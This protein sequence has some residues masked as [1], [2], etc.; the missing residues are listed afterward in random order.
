DHP[1]PDRRHVRHR[2]RPRPGSHR[3]RRP[4][5]AAGAR[6]RRR[7]G[8]E[9]RLPPGPGAARRPGRSRHPQRRRPSGRRRRG[10]A[11]PCRG[12]RR[13]RP[14]LS[15]APAR[16]GG[17]DRCQPHVAGGADPRAAAPPAT[18]PG[19]RRVRELLSR[20]DGERR[21]VGVR[22][23]QV[24]APGVRRRAACR[25]D[26]ERRAR[27]DGLSEPDGHAHAGEGARAGGA[28]LRRVAVD[29]PRDGRHD[30]PARAR[31]A[32]RRDDPRRH[33]PSG[34]AA[35]RHL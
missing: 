2:C 31:P 32:A 12:G 23:V 15:A 4:R 7:V 21:L 29:Q 20:A 30:D 34:D 19:N 16:L 27:D 11:G 25:G 8:V 6:R 35:T 9:R 33:R 14:R 5:G 17:A 3:P 1:R 26:R 13:A 10:V 18:E 22:G 28:H 24:R